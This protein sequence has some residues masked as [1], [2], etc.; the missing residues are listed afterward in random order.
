MFPDAATANAIQVI[1]LLGNGTACV[2]WSSPLP[3]EAHAPLRYV[4]L[5]GSRKP[6]LLVG[7]RNNLGAETRLAYAPSTRFYLEDEQAGRPWITRLPFPVQVVERVEVYDWIGRSRFVTL[8]AYHHG[9]FDGEER[10]FRGFG[11]VEQWDTERHRDDALFPDVEPANERAESFVPPMRTRTWFHT[12]AFVE[13]G[14]VSRQFATEY[15]VEPALR[16]DTPAA[17][18]ERE[19]M[20]LPDTVLEA[21]LTASETRE[22]CRALKGSILRSEVYA[23]DGTPRAEH[24]YIVTE[25]NYTVTRV[26]PF[27]PNRHAVFLTHARES[28]SYHY[29]RQPSDPRVTHD[30]TLA[31]D[32]FAN[33]L[34]SVSIGYGRRPGY[35]EPEPALSRSF[36]TMLAHD[37]G[38]LHLRATVNGY[39]N[40]VNRPTDATGI[41]VYRSP[42]PVETTVAELAGTTPAARF[43]AFGEMDGHV[44]AFWTGA[45]DVPPEQV[46][47]PT[48]TASVSR[49][50]GPSCG[51]A[52][53]DTLPTRRHDRVVAGRG[54]R[55]A[56]APRRDLP[57]GADARSRQPRVRHTRHGP[58]AAG[59]WIRPASSAERLV[60]PVR[61]S[62]LFP[63]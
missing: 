34:R 51:R 54:G 27:G 47:T 37:Q 29:E 32:E 62:V 17:R 36:R 24:P 50:T 31:V 43:F 41:D 63:R 12:G 2:V 22:A 35:P 11:M 57:P 1:D 42:L 9:Y 40:P 8:Y 49:R 44:L 3:G 38:R 53:A 21:G 5:M 30:M 55:V 7:T 39:T 16:V 18:A 45:Q 15:W 26:Q 60:D 61:P 58:D 13:A 59:R 4:D 14:D 10:E 52:H 48:S 28:R 56:G 33:V 19:A 23:D 20:L 25:Q 6:H 46:S